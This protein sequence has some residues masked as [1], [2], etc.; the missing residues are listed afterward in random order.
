MKPRHLPKKNNRTRDLR[1]KLAKERMIAKK[2]KLT[3]YPYFR[4]FGR[5]Y[6]ETKE[7]QWD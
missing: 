6:G 5:F 2:L 4:E 1:E 7:L 3:L